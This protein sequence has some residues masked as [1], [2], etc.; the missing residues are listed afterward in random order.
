MTRSARLLAVYLLAAVA[1]LAPLA[2]IA[3]LT[4]APFRSDWLRPERPVTGPRLALPNDVRRRLDRID[5]HLRAG[6]WE[7]ARSLAERSVEA[8]QR[9]RRVRWNGLAESLA[10]QALAEAALGQEEE[11]LWHWTEAQNLDRRVLSAADL[12]AFG[13]SGALLDSRRLREP[14]QVPP[15]LGPRLEEPPAGTAQNVE[16]V[17]KLEG[18]LPRPAP[19]LRELSIPAWLRAEVVVDAGGRVREPVVLGASAPFLVVQVL[20]ALRGWRF[21]PAKVDGVAV[22]VLYDLS[23][24]GPSETPLAEMAP[25]LKPLADVERMLRAGE[26]TEAHARASRLWASWL[27]RS[28]QGAGELAVLLTLRALAEAGRG[29]TDAAVCRWQAAQSLEPLLFHADLSAYG[30]PGEV[31]EQKRWGADNDGVVPKGAPTPPVVRTRTPP[32]YPQL[33]QARG[34][35][36]RVEVEVVLDATGAV[37]EPMI[38]GGRSVSQ[39]LN[40]SALDTLCDWRFEPAMLAG[41]PVPVLYHLTINY[42]LER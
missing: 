7:K 5:E 2:P 26:W 17:R 40:A 13:D 14:G 37:R 18:D 41:Q 29:E 3:P 28:E 35:E 22:A 30:A 32:L 33:L 39:N 11:A 19:H 10:R 24:N 42:E 12:K 27:D 21:E 36:E 16:K 34:V 8:I 9:D 23:V 15:A 1:S 4:A 31:L 20:E 6:E 25:L 38:I